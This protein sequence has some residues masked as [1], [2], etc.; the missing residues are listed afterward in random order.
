MAR[1]VFDE[2]SE[3][4]PRSGFTVGIDDDV[5]FTS[6][7]YDETF[8]IEPDD[9]ARAV[10]YG[11]GA[12]GTVGAAKNTIKIIGDETDRFAQGYFVYDSKK[13][14]ST[15]VSHL[16]FGP[17]P[18]RS[19]YLVRRARFVGCH[20]WELLERL[21]VLERAAEG[22]TVLLNSPYGPAEVWAHLP[23]RVRRRIVQH[24]YRLFVIDASRVAQ[25]AG[26]GR[27]VN[28]VLQTCFFA[29][30]GVLPR[31]E[32]IAAIK[33]AVKKTYGSK[34]EAV[35]QQNFAAIDQ[36]LA[37]LHEVTVPAAAP[38]D[39]DGPHGERDGAP[40]FVRTVLEPIIENRGDELP[41]SVFPIDGTYPVGTSRWEKRNLADAIPVWDE[42]ICI[43]CNKCALVCPHAAIRV[44]A[45]PAH[46]LAA[47]P[48]TFR[49]VDYK[50]AEY[51]G[52][53]YTVQV[54]PED[55]TGCELCVEICPA[56]DKKTGD[57][58]LAMRPQLP[59]RADER[60]NFSFFLDLPEVDR[61]TAKRATVKGCQFLEPLFEFSGACAGCGETPYLKLVTQLFGDR[62]IVA[63]ATGCSSIFGGNLPTTPWTCNDEGRGPAWSNSLFEDNA[64][65][66]YGMRLTV[67]KHAGEA[68]ALVAR[69]RETIGEPLAAAILD[70]RQES[71][72]DIHDQR[73]RVAAL[74]RAL[75]AARDARSVRASRRGG[76]PSAR[77]RGLSR[78]EVGLDRRWRRLGVRH[79]LRRPRPRAR[80]RRATSTSSSSTP[81]CT[82]TPAGRCRRRRRAA[83]SRKFAAAG[84]PLGEE[85]P[86]PARDDLRHRLRRAGRAR[87]ERHAD[88]QGDSR[89]RIVRRPVARDRLRP[90][91][92]PRD[93]DQQRAPA[94]GARR[95]VRAL[96]PL[97]FRSAG[98][99]G[100]QES[101]DARFAAAEDLVHR[102]RVRRDTLQDAQSAR[103][104]NRRAPGG[105]GTARRRVP[106]EV[107]RAARG[108]PSGCRAD[109]ACGRSGMSARRRPNAVAPVRVSNHVEPRSLVG[110]ARH[111]LRDLV[112]GANDGIITTFAVVAGVAGGALSGR[113]VLIVGAA[114]LAGRR[115][116]DGRG[117]LPR[118]PIRRKRAGGA[119]VAGGRGAPIRHGAATFLAFVAAGTVPLLPYFGVDRCVALRRVVGV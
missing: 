50:G 37:N 16:R 39:G 9:V 65:F 79:R 91:H 74:R 17:R 46:H 27:R 28:T 42:G 99:V 111:Y 106:A 70:A 114:N 83:R 58:A 10:L 20:Q 41:V 57:L 88:G 77:P 103:P 54:A 25:Q 60:T 15:T 117:E 36:A 38:V 26:M 69:L 44:K 95:G 24:R 92:R 53:K 30:A 13:S 2:L 1:A 115:P 93:R 116:V 84:K 76:P 94:A 96:A 31:G 49:A 108:A 51:A 87:R 52:M 86:R 89:S 100:R 29:L 3:P 85:R 66:G 97:S 110:L 75:H 78:E 4:A 80:V 59:L 90:L 45:Y 22:A 5:S 32:A 61:A 82:R 107:V 7:A 18:I 73:E 23:A 72:A 6:L 8:D 48:P 43:Q 63:N 12:D 55:C 81:R 109:A 11:V 21:D 64:E 118:H 47:A 102:L 40:E 56:R 105:R 35:V 113:A 19:T 34:G 33:R 119:G 112:Y 68:R 14:G 62:M 67:D 71:E 98:G 104:A 101:A